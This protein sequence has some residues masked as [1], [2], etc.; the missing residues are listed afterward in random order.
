LEQIRSSLF[1]PA[2]DRI[3][4]AEKPKAIYINS[5]SEDWQQGLVA[6]AESSDANYMTCL[7]AMCRSDRL[8]EERMVG[9]AVSTVYPDDKRASAAGVI[10]T[11]LPGRCA[12][13]DRA[14]TVEQ[15]QET[16]D[17]QARAANTAAWANALAILGGKCRRRGSRAYNPAL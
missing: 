13:F 1:L 10:L 8:S 6:I 2:L 16:L 14:I 11:S 7:L 4:E 9:T 12:N 5:A 3:S 15:Q 17:A